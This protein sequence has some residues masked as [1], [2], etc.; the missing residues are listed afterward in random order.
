[1]HV[2]QGAFSYL[3][4]LTDDEIRSQL[5]Y[6][7]DRSWVCSIEVTEDPAPRN[8]YWKMWALP[9]FDKPDPE[10]IVAETARCRAA[11]PDQHVKVN[12]LDPALGRQTI[13]LSFIV[14]RPPDRA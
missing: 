3:S 2:T 13:A 4:A 7:I 9:Y 1:M 6:A 14:H 8:R 10:E 11:F 5:R 12:A